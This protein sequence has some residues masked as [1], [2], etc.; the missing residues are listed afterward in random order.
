[1]AKLLRPNAREAVLCESIVL[2]A[3]KLG[4][5][6]VAEGV[7][8]QQQGEWLASI[9]CDY[10]QGYQYYRPMTADALEGIVLAPAAS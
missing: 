2:L 3:H 8:A 5:R 1:M 9:G 10:V 7:E 4:I 6:V